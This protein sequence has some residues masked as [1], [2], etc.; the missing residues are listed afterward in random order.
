[1]LIFHWMN[2]WHTLNPDFGIKICPIMMR[3]TGALCGPL[4]A[5][6]VCITWPTRCNWCI[7]WPTTYN[8]ILYGP[9]M[10][11]VYYV[12]CCV[13]IVH[14]HGPLHAHYALG[15]SILWSDPQTNSITLYLC[16]F[17]PSLPC[18]LFVLSWWQRLSNR[19]KRWWWNMIF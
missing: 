19:T 12:A 3:A 16:H 7:T 8:G 14:L 6:G 4:C 17:R 1:M 15:L 13:Q 9:Y 2:I 5:T 18:G 11:L 10:Q